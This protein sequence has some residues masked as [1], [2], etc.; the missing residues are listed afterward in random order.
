MNAVYH[1]RRVEH[2]NSFDGRAARFQAGISDLNRRRLPGVGRTSQRGTN[3]LW[4]FPLP[5]LPYK[6]VQLEG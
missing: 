4:R 2:V 5:S 3:R 6:A 1:E